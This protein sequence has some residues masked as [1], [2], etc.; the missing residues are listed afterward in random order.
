VVYL[1]S[2]Y[3]QLLSND[4]PNCHDLAEVSNCFLSG[5]TSHFAPLTCEE[6]QLDFNLPGE[7]LID[8]NKVY[9]ELRKIRTNK[10]PGLDM[11][12]NKILKVFAYELAPVITDIYNSSII[13]GVFPMNLKRSIVVPIPKV[14]LPQSVEDDLRPIQ[15]YLPKLRVNQTRS[16]LRYQL[17]NLRLTP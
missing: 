2:W 3:N 11:I 10:S 17:G 16:S 5:L 1:P 6:E 13:Q 9:N 14:S 15:N 8:A 7:Y 12:S 4:V